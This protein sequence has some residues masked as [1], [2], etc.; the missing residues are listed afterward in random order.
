MLKLTKLGK[1]TLSALYR[2]KMDLVK[3][4]PYRIIRLNSEFDKSALFVQ[5][6][7]FVDQKQPTIGKEWRTLATLDV[8]G[9]VIFKSFTSI[10]AII[11]FFKT[12]SLE[13]TTYIDVYISGFEMPFKVL[14]TFGQLYE[15][16]PE[17][18]I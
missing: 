15:T 2:I 9:E 5:R 11:V 12:Q 7:V 13:K 4:A 14:G 1:C 3:I 8:F 16:S 6:E 10:P 17:Y 18:F